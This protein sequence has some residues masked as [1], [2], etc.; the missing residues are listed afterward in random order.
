MTEGAVTTRRSPIIWALLCVAFILTSVILAL[1]A[2]GA[3]PGV[4][5]VPATACALVALLQWFRT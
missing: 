1:T 5:F 3:W 2:G 4:L